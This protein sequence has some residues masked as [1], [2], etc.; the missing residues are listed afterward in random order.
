MHLLGRLD[1]RLGLGEAP[2]ADPAAGEKAVARI[3]ELHAARRQRLQVALHGR[4]LEHVGVHRRREQHRRARRQVERG[5]EV[6]GDAVGELADDVG[7][8]RRDEQQTD[9][10]RQRDVLDVGVGAARELVGDRPA[11]A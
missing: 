5:Q 3:D 6:V 10:G 4:V 8:G 7:G 11:G 1:D 2:L 9:V